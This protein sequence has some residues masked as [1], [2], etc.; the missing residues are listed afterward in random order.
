MDISNPLI[1]EIIKLA[2]KNLFDDFDYKINQLNK[3]NSLLKLKLEL[4][5]IPCEVLDKA[6]ISIDAK[7]NP[8]IV[9]LIDSKLELKLTDSYGQSETKIIN[10]KQNEQI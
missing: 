2:H 3:E 10:L 6:D 1:Q 4:A 7:Y 5:N 9:E 8:M